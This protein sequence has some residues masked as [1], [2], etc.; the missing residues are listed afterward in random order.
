MLADSF[1]VG[2]GVVPFDYN[3]ATVAERRLQRALG[4]RFDR[5]AVHN[6]GV[7]GVGL[8]EYYYLTLT[9]VLPT[10]PELVAVCLFV[11]NDVEIGLSQRTELAGYTLFKNWRAVELPKRLWR[12]L[13]ERRRGHLAIVGTID[14]LPKGVPAYLHDYRLE[15]PTFSESRFMQIENERVV[16]C[17]AKRPDIADRYE[18][19]FDFLRKFRSVLGRKLLVV[20]IPDEFQVNDGLWAKLMSAA[21]D[22]GA[23]D[24]GLP[25]KRITGFCETNGIAILDL[26]PPLYLAQQQEPAYQLRDTHWNA[27]GNRVAGEAIADW[28]LQTRFGDLRPGASD[29]GR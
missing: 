23:L 13:Y 11:G 4:G 1:G 8:P 7:A 21:A 22:R 27:R 26:L 15:P 10:R 5:V 28:V 19:V 2:G 20:L 24:R 6:F 25:Q 9:E 29:A 17:D 3:F 12:L 18:G 14:Q 16:V